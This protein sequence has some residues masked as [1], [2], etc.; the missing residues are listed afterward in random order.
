MRMMPYSRFM[1]HSNR[2]SQTFHF[3][4]KYSCIFTNRNN[5]VRI[6]HNVQARNTG[7]CYFPG[8]IHRIFPPL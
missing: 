1:Y 5:L 2:N 7:F 6:A 3:F 4:F 8:M